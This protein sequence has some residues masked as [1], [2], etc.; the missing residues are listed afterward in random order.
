MES[1]AA[2]EL[3]EILVSETRAN[4]SVRAILATKALEGSNEAIRTL[5]LA[6]YPIKK[7]LSVINETRNKTSSI[8]PTATRKAILNALST[9]TN[10]VIQGQ[11]AQ[12]IKVLEETINTGIELL[13]TA[14]AIKHHTFPNNEEL[15]NSYGCRDEWRST[16]L[17]TGVVPMEYAGNE[18]CYGLSCGDWVAHT[19]VG[20][21]KKTL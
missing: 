4:A 1:K 13:N 21:M 6:E 19:Y 8:I 10:L 9:S 12:A 11:I 7:L 17:I 20:S 2:D 18:E 14:T 15:R 3:I 5:T 16:K